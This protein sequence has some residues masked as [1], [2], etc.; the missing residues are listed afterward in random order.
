MFEIDEQVKRWRIRL[1]KNPIYASSDVDELES[2]LR[3][4]IAQLQSKE[5]AAEEA[6]IVAAHRLGDSKCLDEEYAKISACLYLKRS[7]VFIGLGIYTSLIL[8]LV[9][10]VAGWHAAEKEKAYQQA[11]EKLSMENE[12]L[13]TH[14][15]KQ[16]EK[17]ANLVATIYELES[18]VSTK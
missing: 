9:M 3:E 16:L 17:K 4:E 15:I 10:M 2:H 5:L 12:R 11:L 7:K 8:V 6:F 1:K 13:S 14:L 18:R